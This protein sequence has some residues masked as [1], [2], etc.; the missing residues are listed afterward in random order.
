M[1]S[2]ARNSGARSLFRLILTACLLLVISV[3]FALGDVL[4]PEKLEKSLEYCRVVASGSYP[5]WRYADFTDPVTYYDMN[6]VPIAYVYSVK[7]D[8]VYLGSMTVSARDDFY[9][10]FEYSEGLQP[11]WGLES[12]LNTIRDMGYEPGDVQY[13]YAPPFDYMVKI[14]PKNVTDRALADGIVVHLGSFEVCPKVEV[15]QYLERYTDVSMQRRD[16]VRGFWRQYVLSSD[17]PPTVKQGADVLIGKIVNS[18]AHD[19][20]F[21]W[22]KGCGPTSITMMLGYYGNA[23][24]YKNFWFDG[25]ESFSWCG[26]TPFTIQE[27]HDKVVEFGQNL[28]DGSELGGPGYSGCILM[29]YGIARDTARSTIEETAKFYGYTF[30]TDMLTYDP[31]RPQPGVSPAIVTTLQQEIDK[32]HPVYFGITSDGSG[33]GW[34]THAVLGVGYNYSAGS[35]QVIAHNTWWWSHGSKPHA[36]MSNFSMWCIITAAPLGFFNTPPDLTEP[37]VTPLSGPPGTVFTFTVHYYDRDEAAFYVDGVQDFEPFRAADDNG[38]NWV[39]GPLHRDYKGDL[40]ANNGVIEYESWNDMGDHCSDDTWY[41]SPASDPWPDPADWYSSQYTP[42]NPKDGDTFIDLNNNGQWEAERFDDDNCNGMWD[43]DNGPYEGWVVIDEVGYAMLMLGN[44]AVNKRSDC[45]YEVNVRLGPGIHRYYYYFKDGNGGT[46]RLPARGGTYENVRVGEQYNAGPV[47]TNASVSPST[48]SRITLFAYYV[49]YYDADGDAPG[50]PYV[51]IDGVPYQMW[52][53]SGTAADGLYKYESFLTETDHRYYFEFGDIYGKKGR[54]PSAGDISGPLVLGGGQVPM[55]SDGI[56]SPRNPLVETPVTFTVRYTSPHDYTPINKTVVV[57]GSPREMTFLEGVTDQGL[58][59]TIPDLANFASGATYYCRISNL[60]LGNHSFYFSFIDETGGAGRLPTKGEIS[61]PD[62]SGTNTPPVLTEAMVDPASGTTTTEFLF[63]ARYSDINANPPGQTL[64]YLDG[65]SYEMELLSGTLEHG[66]YG[67]PIAGLSE[68]LHS[69]WFY[70]SD[71]LG[72]ETRMPGTPGD[73]FEGPYVRKTNIPPDLSNPR[74]SPET[75]GFFDRYVFSVDYFDEQGDAPALM[76][77]W[78]DGAEHG[79]WLASGDD[80]NGTYAY[81]ASPGTLSTGEHHYYFFANDGYG[82]TARIPQTGYVIG[83][84]VKHED[85]AA[86]PYWLVDGNMSPRV[87][88]SIVMTNPG[89]DPVGVEVSLSRYNGQLIEPHLL[90]V[91]GKQT[92][93]LKISEIQGVASSDS[94][95][96]NINWKTGSLILWAKLDVGSSISMDMASARPGPLQMPFWQVIRGNSPGRAGLTFDTFIALANQFGRDVS[97]DITLFDEFGAEIDTIHAGIVPFGTRALLLS[98]TI[99]GTSIGSAK[100]VFS[101]PIRVWAVMLNRVRGGGFE[102]PVLEN[103]ALSPYMVPSWRNQP[104]LSLDTYIVFS[105][106]GDK[107]ASPQVSFYNDLGVIRGADLAS[108]SPGG[109][110][111][112]QASRCTMAGESGSAR[113]IWAND[114]DMGVFAVWLNA[115][116]SQ[117]YPVPASK[118]YTPPIYIPYWEFDP[119]S[120]ETLVWV[121]NPNDVSVAGKVLVNDQRGFLVGELQFNVLPGGLFQMPVSDADTAGYGCLTITSDTLPPL[122]LIA[123]ALLLNTNGSGCLVEAQKSMG[124]TLP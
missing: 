118:S 46:S 20:E 74:V 12:S 31:P 120:K 7:R 76:S 66:V 4:T 116:R 91:A 110:S 87:E 43:G 17:G 1:A 70:A 89:Q 61:G 40:I 25:P 97:A 30:V 119:L 102:L 60:A 115:K 27:L 35:H 117:F 80:Y 29:R 63:S 23:W 51:F 84:L 64:L 114:N 21:T 54:W 124:Q 26:S 81:T 82:G 28:G 88:T 10:F 8:N 71:S 105:N 56:V 36:E 121:R 94:G 47:L 123:W 44:P 15:A 9:P 57:D 86:I 78:L 5:Q 99:A 33:N 83:P 37:S 24:G 90:M 53:I 16:E 92:K 3:S 122:P 38:G 77:V 85:E 49:H 42:Y 6:G 50:S 103:A 52:L 95:T 109:M 55:L 13:V 14:K 19:Y 101:D 108:V 67:V 48:G 107:P 104:G 69:Y 98:D 113:A 75:G 68:G 59:T 34:N 65:E 11:S 22:Y 73:E 62:V 72:A 41:V 39:D 106:L 58:T 100:M 96:G 93:V 45:Y 112:I 2:L 79:M 32:N 18:E 111:I